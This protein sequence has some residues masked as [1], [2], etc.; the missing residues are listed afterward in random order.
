MQ[1]R[2]YWQI[3]DGDR[4][5]VVPDLADPSTEQDRGFQPGVFPGTGFPGLEPGLESPAACVP[6]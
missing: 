3:R 1:Q 5:R 2:S 4:V 6:N